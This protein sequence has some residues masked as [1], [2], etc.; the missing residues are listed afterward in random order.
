MEISK[1]AKLV[2]YSGLAAGI[3]LVVL[4]I[5]VVCNK[6]WRGNVLLSASCI[7]VFA[8]LVLEVTAFNYPFYLRFFA[9]PIVG[10]AEVS[11]TDSSI[12]ILTDGTRAAVIDS[13]V[14]FSKLNMNIASV[15]A[16]IDYINAETAVM[17][18]KYTKQ[19]V[20]REYT[21]RLYKYTPRENYA[22]LYIREGVSKCEISF[23]SNIPDTAASL[24]VNDIVINK[25][26]PFYFSGLRLLVISLLL[27]VIF[28]LV[29]KRLRASYW[30][31]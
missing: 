3:I 8:A 27:F 1:I 4:A 20:T 15:F 26:I 10:F 2:E 9:G 6:K 23:S 12:V 30:P 22:P 17:L 29:N 19:G 18:I 25:P 13:G 16:D 14:R 7:A 21:K 5:I 24:E 31:V 28:S 11:Q